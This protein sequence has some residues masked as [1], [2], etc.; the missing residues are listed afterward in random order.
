[1]PQVLAKLLIAFAASQ[2]LYAELVAR[3]PETDQW[4]RR[5]MRVLS[6]S[7]GERLSKETGSTLRGIVDGIIGGRPAEATPN[8]ANVS[9]GGRPSKLAEVEMLM[10][11]PA[12]SMN[13]TP[14]TVSGELAALDLPDEPQYLPLF[15]NANGKPFYWGLEMFD[16]D[17][18][19]RS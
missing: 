13:V 19:A 1:M 12:S 3:H 16:N 11:H 15:E 9:S 8:T 4:T 10:L 5:A 18:L 7:T 17:R 6:S 14:S 2:W